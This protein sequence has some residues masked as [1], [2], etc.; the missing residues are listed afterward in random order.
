MKCSG[1][2]KSKFYKETD[3]FFISLLINNTTPKNP[4]SLGTRL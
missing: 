2:A 3:G 4:N 1:N